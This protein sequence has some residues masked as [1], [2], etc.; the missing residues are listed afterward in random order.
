MRLTDEMHA[1]IMA[2]GA[3]DA[4]MQSGEACRLPDH[5]MS[6]L[7][8]GYEMAIEDLLTI[9]LDYYDDCFDG[10]F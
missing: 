2:F 9:A 8:S 5:A 3:A 10:E 7:Q 4:S 6:V 1:A